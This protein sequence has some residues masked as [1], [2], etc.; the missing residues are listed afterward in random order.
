MQCSA[1]TEDQQ[2]LHVLHELYVAK[3]VKVLVTVV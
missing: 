2:T 1:S 3:L